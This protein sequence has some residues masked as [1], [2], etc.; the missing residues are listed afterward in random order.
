MEEYVYSFTMLGVILFGAFIGLIFS[1]YYRVDTS[2]EFVWN[3]MTAI[4]ASLQGKL[5]MAL[6]LTDNL[7]IPSQIILFAWVLMLLYLKKYLL[8][9]KNIRYLGK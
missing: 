6:S 7:H 4:I 3:I 8:G 5:L 1:A 9:V 2:R